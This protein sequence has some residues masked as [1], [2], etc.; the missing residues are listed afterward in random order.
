M[1]LQRNMRSK[2]SI[3]AFIMV[4][5]GLLACGRHLPGAPVSSTLVPGDSTR[6]LN[7]DGLERSYILHVPPGYDGT[8]PMAVVLVFHGGGGNAENAVRMTGFSAQADQAGFLAVYPN[9]TGRLEDKVLTWNGGTCCGYAQEFN[10]DDV[11]FVRAILADLQSLTAID[12]KRIYATGMSNGGILS[13]RLACEASDLIAAIGPVSGTQNFTPCEPQEPVSVIHFHGT[14]DQHLPYAGGVGVD[15]LVGADFASVQN[16]IQ[17]WL[18]YDQCPSTATSEDFA[19]IEHIA[20][21]SCAQG[22][23]VELYTIV[24][25]GHAWPGSNGPGWVGGDQPTMSISATQMLW[26]FFAAHPKP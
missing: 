17:F 2:R 22:S 18:D 24:G 19:D 3:L 7:L 25:G 4:L 21:T 13:Y 8:Q 20:Y 9:G 10:V 1:L 6:T 16:S 11:G 14:D 15:S 26:E 5:I 23:A 12:T